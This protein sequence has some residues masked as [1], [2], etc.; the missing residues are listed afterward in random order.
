MGIYKRGKT[1]WASYQKHGLQV[2]T[3]LK[4]GS[5]QVALIRYAEIIKTSP[6]KIKETQD[7]GDMLA[8]SQLALVG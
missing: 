5:K 6:Q 1:W 4:T 3:S 8:L 7:K 2:R